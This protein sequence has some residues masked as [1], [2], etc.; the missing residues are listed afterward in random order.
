MTDEKQHESGTNAGSVSDEANEWFRT[1]SKHLNINFIP[2]ASDLPFEADIPDYQIATLRAVLQTLV[3]SGRITD[4]IRREVHML[5]S[6]C[7]DKVCSA[8]NLRT[9]LS[10]ISLIGHSMAVREH[11]VIMV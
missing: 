5:M 7:V 2:G 6:L 9:P 8:R 11:N 10:H 3:E 4:V 1:F